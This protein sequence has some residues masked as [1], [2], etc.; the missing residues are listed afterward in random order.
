M[1]TSLYLH[2]V[3]DSLIKR[4]PVQR[5]QAIHLYFLNK[6]MHCKSMNILYS[7]RE[8]FCFPFVQYS[9]TLKTW[10]G[11]IDYWFLGTFRWTLIVS[12]KIIYHTL[13]HERNSWLW[14]WSSFSKGSYWSR[15][16][17]LLFHSTV[18][19]CT[20]PYLYPKINDKYRPKVGQVIHVNCPT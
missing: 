11:L 16:N 12:L 19:R 5:D 14:L 18:K 7:S 2:V 15:I 17:F 13:L 8:S 6:W 10:K 20:K 1:A 3:L 4:N 9:G